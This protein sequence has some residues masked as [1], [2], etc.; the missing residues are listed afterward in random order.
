MEW[1][2]CLSH[3]NTAFKSV[4]Q[5]WPWMLSRM[6][7]EFLFKHLSPF[8]SWL[9]LLL[10]TRLLLTAI[11]C[12]GQHPQPHSNLKMHTN[13]FWFKLIHGLGL[14]LWYVGHWNIQ[15]ILIIWGH[16]CIV[17]IEQRYV[18]LSS[19]YSHWCVYTVCGK[20]SYAKY[21]SLF[22]ESG[23]SLYVRCEAFSWCI[24]LSWRPISVCVILN[25]CFCMHASFIALAEGIFWRSCLNDLS[26]IYPNNLAASRA[27]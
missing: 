23:M 26:P 3:I 12:T 4:W 5:M 17:N 7:N 20:Q 21:Y 16:M 2:K 18:L 24:L 15:Y 14:F 13:D 27:G 8:I 19:F 1:V 11:L 10:S 22:P 9:L 25:V 6:D